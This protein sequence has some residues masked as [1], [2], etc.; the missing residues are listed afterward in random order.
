VIEDSPVIL[1]PRRRASLGYGVH[2]LA[3]SD[4]TA[5]RTDNHIVRADNEPGL[6]QADA[7]SRGGLGAI[8]MFGSLISIG[9]SRSIRPKPQNHDGGG[10]LQASRKLPARVVQVET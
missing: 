10:V 8:V 9:V 4:W 6:S 5:A 2:V 7:L 3:G 1:R